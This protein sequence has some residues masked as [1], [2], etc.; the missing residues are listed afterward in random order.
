MG[1]PDKNATGYAQNDLSTMAAGLKGKLFILHAM[2]DENVHFQNSARLID[3]LTL[4]RKAVRPPPLSGRT[5]RLP[6]P[7]GAS[8]R[9]HAY[10]R[11]PRA[12]SLIERAML[13]LY[14]FLAV[15]KRLQGSARS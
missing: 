4:A 5:A 14:D 12:K 10:R 15:G 1:L 3:A 8:I 9:E 13:R 6:K 7:T 11:L 2:M